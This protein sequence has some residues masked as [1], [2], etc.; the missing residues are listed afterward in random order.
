MD[1][2]TKG[3]KHGA[4]TKVTK[5]SKKKKNVES[6]YRARAEWAKQI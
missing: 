3:G 2:R 5:S 4:R 1:G 6:H